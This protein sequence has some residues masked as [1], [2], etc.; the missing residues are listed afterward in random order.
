MVVYDDKRQGTISVG[1]ANNR[2]VVSEVISDGE[3]FF[4][5]SYIVATNLSSTPVEFEAGER[6]CYLEVYPIVYVDYVTF[7]G[8][9]RGD[10]AFGSTGK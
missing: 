4:K 7:L 3:I 6:L 1:E 9:E 2:F 8:D 10:G 5:A